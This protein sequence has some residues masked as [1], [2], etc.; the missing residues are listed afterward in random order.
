MGS[1]FNFTGPVNHLSIYNSTTDADSADSS[2]SRSSAQNDTNATDAA[3]LHST[4]AVL[5]AAPRMSPDNALT[6][7]LPSSDGTSLVPTVVPPIAVGVPRD[8]SPLD[9]PG[10]ATFWQGILV[11]GIILVFAVFLVIAHVSAPV[12]LALS[13]L[14]GGISLACLR[15]FRQ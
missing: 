14:V 7:V 10:F 5:I 15:I 13:T 1:V 8:D 9:F 12:I 4:D 11:L 3:D 2:D 6:T